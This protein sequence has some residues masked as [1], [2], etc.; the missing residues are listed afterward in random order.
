MR[1]NQ[2][3]KLDQLLEVCKICPRQKQFNHSVSAE[4][5][6]KGCSTYEQIRGI[7]E[8]LGRKKQMARVAFDIPVSDYIQL[9]A[10][11]NKREIA[12]HLNVSEGTLYAWINKNNA[13]I[14][15][16]SSSMEPDTAEIKPSE[17]HCTKEDKSAEY[18]RVITGLKHEISALKATCVLNKEE[19][20]K[21]MIEKEKLENVNAACEDVEN[22][23]ASLQKENESLKKLKYHNDYIIENQ[24]YQ[25]EKWAKEVE[26][27]QEEN[28]ALKFFAKKYLAVE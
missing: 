5:K 26:E 1:I 2:L 6:C 20:N 25:L 8:N 22:E 12:K 19:F 4:V 9:Q 24:K 3:H 11:M 28:K 23:T 10:E 7:G 27:L 18:E 21:L 15:Q 13:E 14:K 17:C 16:L